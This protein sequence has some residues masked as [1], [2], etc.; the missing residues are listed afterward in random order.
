MRFAENTNY[1][2]PGMLLQCLGHSTHG[3]LRELAA[4]HKDY[5]RANPTARLLSRHVNKQ[6]LHVPSPKNALLC[7]KR[8]L[9][10]IRVQGLG[11]CD[12]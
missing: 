1:Q 11:F 4:V 7:A 8:E 10:L 9:L 2:I 12:I 6:Q 3:S 5:L